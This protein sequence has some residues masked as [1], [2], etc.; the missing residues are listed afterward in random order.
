[1]ESTNLRAVCDIFLRYSREIHRKATPKDPNFL[2]ICVACGKIEQFVETVFPAST[3][4]RLRQMQ[5]EADGALTPEERKELN[6]AY[7]ILVGVWIVLFAI[8][9]FIAWLCGAKFDWIFR[10]AG[11]LFG[12]IF[13]GEVVEGTP[14]RVEL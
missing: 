3:N 5:L 13:G 14:G 9:A 4:A 2:A 7:P 1:M 10:N 11:K 8:V 6:E 12:T